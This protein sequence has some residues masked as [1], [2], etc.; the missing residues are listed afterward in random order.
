[1]PAWHAELGHAEM[2]H[3]CEDDAISALSER[4]PLKQRVSS[5]DRDQQFRRAMTL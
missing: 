5:S 2:A 3:A 1:M 4:N